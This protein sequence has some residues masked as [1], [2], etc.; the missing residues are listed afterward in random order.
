[1]K[2]PGH[3]AELCSSAYCN[4]AFKTRRFSAPFPAALCRRE[5]GQPGRNRPLLKSPGSRRQ[6]CRC[7]F[8]VLPRL[9]R[10][11]ATLFADSRSE[12]E[13]GVAAW[14]CR[15]RTAPWHQERPS[16]IARRPGR[17]CDRI[18]AE[19]GLPPV[20]HRVAVR[21]RSPE[22]RL[23]GPSRRVAGGGPRPRRRR[24]RSPRGSRPA[25]RCASMREQGG[26]ALSAG[27]RGMRWGRRRSS[28]GYR[29][30][31]DGS[32]TAQT[33]VSTRR[34]GYQARPR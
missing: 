24:R 11:G 3:I 19:E 31:A 20:R 7:R 9:A 17:R 4:H 34:R 25:R 23:R 28:A 30:R 26:R 32:R 21:V 33:R 1:M 22:R 18:E 12:L 27:Q 6:Q 2:P 5:K 13:A 15:R 8:V 10:H 16:A 29:R 14:A